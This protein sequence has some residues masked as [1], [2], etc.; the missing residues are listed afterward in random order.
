MASAAACHRGAAARPRHS[1]HPRPARRAPRRGARRRATDI[2]WTSSSESNCCASSPLV[3]RY[4][5]VSGVYDKPILH[6]ELRDL[7]VEPI[8]ARAAEFE[9]EHEIQRDAFLQRLF[10]RRIERELE[11]GI[12]NVVLV[13]GEQL[14]RLDGDRCR[15]ARPRPTAAASRS[16][17]TGGRGGVALA[18]CHG[19]RA[20]RGPCSFL[21]KKGVEK[22]V[23]IVLCAGPRWQELSVVVV[24]ARGKAQR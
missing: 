17:T 12:E 16:G 14:C 10:Q 15:R 5:R 20:A 11:L 6:R 4:W 8:P 23:M 21:L 2:R 7:F 22:P 18:A 1:A 3:S 9:L 13:L 24:E 19:Q